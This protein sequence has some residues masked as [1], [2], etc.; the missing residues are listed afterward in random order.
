MSCVECRTALSAELDGEAADAVPEEVRRHLRDCAACG[1]WL[2][3][4]H[5]LQRL[6]RSARLAADRGE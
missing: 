5:R 4:A 6:L 3:A 2:A 1:S